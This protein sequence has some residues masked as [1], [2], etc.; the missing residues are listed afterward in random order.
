MAAR[1][2]G[3][4]EDTLYGWRGREKQEQAAL[5]PAIDRRSEA[6]FLAENEWL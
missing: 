2:F 1:R 5:E 6:D 4:K 3:L